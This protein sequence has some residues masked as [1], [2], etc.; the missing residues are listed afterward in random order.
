ML[1]FRVVLNVPRLWSL[2]LVVAVMWRVLRAALLRK[3][4]D[5]YGIVVVVVIGWMVLVF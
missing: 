2:V 5:P 1:P 3:K 4:T